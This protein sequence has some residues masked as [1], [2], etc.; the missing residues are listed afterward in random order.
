LKPPGTRENFSSRICWVL[1]RISTIPGCER[2]VKALDNQI[3]VIKKEAVGLAKLRDEFA[4]L[5]TVWGIGKVLALTVMC[6]VGEIARF[7]KVA[8]FASYCRLVRSNRISAG[9]RK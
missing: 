1:S 8:N 2:P 6:E 7:R 5:L 9:R 4:P 3:R